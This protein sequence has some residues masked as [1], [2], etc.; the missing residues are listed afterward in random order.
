M[1]LEDGAQRTYFI[2]VESQDVGRDML[3]SE[4]ESMKA[5]HNVT[6]D[7]VPEPIAWG[8]YESIPDTYFLLTEFRDMRP[9]MPDPDKF[10]ARLSALHQDS[11]SPEGK[12]GFHTR[13]HAGNIPQYTEWEDSWEVF[14]TKSMRQALDLEIEAKGN[15]PE[16]EE[17]I[18]TLFNTVIPRLLRPLESDGCRVK[19]SLIHGD[20]WFAN[21]GIDADTDEPLVFDACCFYAHNECE[22]RHI[23]QIYVLH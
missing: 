2:K 12:F 5:I 9:D 22:L 14:F 23:F 16:C 7:F 18:P 13:T 19:P 17:L 1:E 3:S 4:H 21:S 20:L 15:D 6:P 11:E 8:K 10:A